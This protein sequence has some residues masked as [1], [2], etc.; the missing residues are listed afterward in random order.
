[1]I[2]WPTS[3]STPC[4]IFRLALRD[5]PIDDVLLR[6][7][8]PLHLPGFTVKIH[9]PNNR[10]IQSSDFPSD[11][12]H[13]SYAA[14]ACRIWF[15]NRQL[16]NLDSPGH[17]CLH[18]AGGRGR[19]AS[20]SRSREPRW[21][22]RAWHQPVDRYGLASPSTVRNRVG[23]HAFGTCVRLIV[24]KRSRY[25]AFSRVVHFPLQREATPWHVYSC[26]RYRGGVVARV[27]RRALSVRHGRR[28]QR[29]LDDIRS[30][31]G[32]LEQMGIGFYTEMH[33]G[34]P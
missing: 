33:C 32:A 15:A 9:D 3:S 28:G 17:T 20:N 21:L 16:R 23:T 5:H 7:A 10:S 30:D 31:L 25:A 24:S 26:R 22:C 13:A 12:R 14:L 18:V 27:C 29:R 8:V 6:E 19:E 4:S 34:V 2:S 1:M 11:Q